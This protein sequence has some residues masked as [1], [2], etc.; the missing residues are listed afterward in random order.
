MPGRR[1]TAE[2]FHRLRTWEGNQPRAFE[3]LCFQL[4]DPEPEGVELRKTSDPD[5]GFEWYWRC[6]DKTEIGWQC[7]FIFDEKTLIS[8]MDASFESVR[9]RRPDAR[10]LTFC[11]PVDLADDPDGARGEFGWQRFDAAKERWKNKAP[12]LEVALL[13]G[14]ELLSRLA[15]ARHRGREWFWFGEPAVLDLEWCRRQREVAITSARERYRPELN[16]NLPVAS[17]LSAVAQPDVLRSR[18]DG[19]V[20]ALLSSV[21]ET[22]EWTTD[23]PYKPVADRVQELALQLQEVAARPWTPTCSLSIDFEAR[24][25]ELRLR[26]YDLLDV[27]TEQG[28]DDP[29]DEAVPDVAPAN[30]DAPA[31]TEAEAGRG[32]AS[33]STDAASTTRPAAA[34]AEAASDQRKRLAVVDPID[35]RRQQLERRRAAASSVEHRGARILAAI[36]A[37][38]EFVSGPAIAAARRRALVLDGDGGS[39]KTHLS[40]EVAG[41]L[42]DAGHP[43]LLLLGQWFGTESPWKTLAERLGDPALGIDDIVGAMEAAAQASGKRLVV[44]VDAINEAGDIRIWRT[45]F[46]DLQARL[47]ASG[48]VSLALTCRT[49][50]LPAI[51]PRGGFGDSIARATH[52]GFEGREF[53]AVE[54]IFAAYEVEQPRVPLLLPEFTNPLFLI[55]YCEA[56]ARGILPP[57]GAAHLT[58]VFEAF[59]AS[60]KADIELELGLDP[61]LNS[62]GEAVSALARELANCADDHLAYADASALV[63]GFDSSGGQWPDTLFGRMLSEGLLSRDHAYLGD[64]QYGEAVRFP[65]QRFSDHLIVREI[66]DARL[67]ANDPSASFAAGMPLADLL[68]RGQL[69]LLDAL[70]IQLPERCG[71][72]LP[73]VGP[74]Q[75]SWRRDAVLRAFLISVS[76]RDPSAVGEDLLQFIDEA[77]QRGLETEVVA[78]LVAVAPLP[79]HRLNGAWLH[80]WL[81]GIPMPERDS[82]WTK[83]TYW[84]RGE[85]AHPLDRLLR[86]AGRGPY[87]GYP[88]EVIE[89]AAIP[90]IWLLASPN[91]FARDDA[92]KGLVTLLRNDLDA[93]RRLIDRFTPV[94]D[95][96]VSERL[97]AVCYGA[98]LRSDPETANREQVF[99]LLHALVGLLE[100]APFPNLLLRDHVAGFA[101]FCE[102]H[103][104]LA[105]SGLLDRALPP[106]G[107]RPPKV[108][109]KQQWLEQTYPRGT[110]REDPQ[111]SALHGSVFGL[112]ADFGRYVINTRVDDFLNQRLSDPPADPEFATADDRVVVNNRKWRR[113]EHSLT[114][115]QLARL[116]EAAEDRHAVGAALDDLTPEQFRLLLAAFAVRSHDRNRPQTY[117]GERAERFVFQRCVELGWTP[118]RFGAFDILVGRSSSGREARKPERFGKKYQ[119]IALFELLG[120]LADTHVFTGS[121]WGGGEPIEYEGAWQLAARDIDPSIPI[122]RVTVGPADERRRRPPFVQDPP[123]AWWVP[124]GPEFDAA[125]RESGDWAHRTDDLP[126]VAGLFLRTDP[127][128]TRWIVLDGR[129]EYE[130]DPRESGQLERRGQPRRDLGLPL[131][132]ALARRSDLPA[133]EGWFVAQPDVLRSLP[134][135]DE[136]AHGDGY[137]GEMPW[138]RAAKYA[139]AEWRT[140][141]FRRREPAL[142]AEVIA[143]AASWHWSDD[144]DCSLDDP[145]NLT[146]PSS[147]V[148]GLDT[149]RWDGDT[150]NWLAGGEAVVTFRETDEGWDRD[151]ALL[152]REDWLLRL[153]DTHGL[154]LICGAYAERRVLPPEPGV[155]EPLGWIDLGAGGLLANGKWRFRGWNVIWDRRSGRDP[156]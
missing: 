68:E 76:A 42:L 79:T 53:D 143:P 10:K 8:A 71:A 145:L 25:E 134:G 44:L 4:R 96:Y 65:Y 74:D 156:D 110:S 70:A 114:A 127:G 125:T 94:D 107:S 24:L 104:G 3:E 118:E 144:H 61:G 49:T 135:W 97:A 14:G 69:G 54:H 22:L 56:L 129:L 34:N 133:V 81:L 111:Y 40:C 84:L 86:W 99:A 13:Q 45:H 32:G 7:K 82:F 78:A 31:D 93:L 155:G 15:E 150:L 128:G 123:A 141:E 115:E 120:R 75:S 137:L 18:F 100:A 87:P 72:E 106:Y 52:P 21:A 126:D 91:R 30:N 88:S 90:L 41:H 124:P 29:P 50:Y 58:A 89:L 47:G 85:T 105:D 122:G 113:F 136:Q 38:D 101:R 1:P 55:L 48:W 16:V 92:T 154:V 23:D 77:L 17:I 119:W 43:V 2:T 59:V 19:E 149:V 102:E 130:D 138:A 39:G 142:P 153:L 116:D 6:P 112:F 98:L 36:S 51:Q 95:V 140:E 33:S 151:W 109:R 121:G 67:N 12:Q 152:A 117:P 64:G 46:D 57:R 63:G 35:L 26:T 62:V 37:L 5:A 103:L 147:Y 80:S 66:L 132:S 27:A 131:H 108:P 83:M 9:N 20:A 148:A 146:L 28:R 60:R 139:R 73:S 11:V